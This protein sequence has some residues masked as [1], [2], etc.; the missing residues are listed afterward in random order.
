M[1]SLVDEAKKQ[2]ENVDCAGAEKCRG[3]IR[4]A[5]QADAET[6]KI[7]QEAEKYRDDGRSHF[8]LPHGRQ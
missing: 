8:R 5:E 2:A 4:K 7:A 1:I 6:E 3:R